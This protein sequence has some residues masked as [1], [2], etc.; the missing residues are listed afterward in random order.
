MFCKLGGGVTPLKCGETYDTDVVVN[1]MKITVVKKNFENRS[2]LFKV[3]NECIV[4]QFLLRH[5]V[6]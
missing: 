3:M 6:Y 4:A 5:S 2:T 1:F